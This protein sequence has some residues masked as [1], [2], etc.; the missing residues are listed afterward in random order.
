M[1]NRS[2]ENGGNYYDN[3][4]KPLYGSI[5]PQIDLYKNRKITNEEVARK[6]AKDIVWIMENPKNKGYNE[7]TG[8]YHAYTDKGADGV[9]HVNIGPGLEKIAHPNIDYKKSYT[10]QELD[11]I[12][13]NTIIERQR[14]IDNSLRTMKNGKYSLTADTLSMGPRLALLDIGHN[15]KTSNR[16]NLPEKWPSLVDYIA[17]GNLD[18]A[19]KETYSGSNRR[20]KMRNQLLTYDKDIKVTNFSNGGI[21]STPVK[22]IDYTALKFASGGSIHIKPEN[23]GKFTATMKRTGKTAEE[24]SHSSNPLTRKRATFALNARKWHH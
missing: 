6:Y 10:K 9:T 24:F 22:G 5:N 15:V 19:K 16:K 13:Y 1:A 14:A 3:N 17:N 7:K 4:Y 21:I 12:A 8:K 18:K 23:R 2:L 20:Q 11:D